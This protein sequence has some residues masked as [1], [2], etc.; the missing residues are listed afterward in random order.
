M[1]KTLNVEGL[2]CDHCGAHVTKA[3]EKV[4]GGA[5]GD[6]SLE[7]NRATVALSADVADQVLIDAVVDAGYAAAIA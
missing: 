6:V 3:R 2:R 5:S 4:E 7:E 1:E